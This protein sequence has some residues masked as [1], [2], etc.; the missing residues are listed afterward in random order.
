MVF[1]SK[2]K[3]A[4]WNPAGPPG[5][6]QRAGPGLRKTKKGFHCLRGLGHTGIHAKGAAQL[7]LVLQTW[8]RMELPLVIHV[9]GCSAQHSRAP[10]LGWGSL[11]SK[12]PN[13]KPAWMRCAGAIPLTSAHCQM[14]PAAATPRKAARPPLLPPFSSMEIS[15][16]IS[17]FPGLALAGL[18]LVAEARPASDFTALVYSLAHFLSFPACALAQVLLFTLCDKRLHYCSRMKSNRM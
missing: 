18:S 12:E 11:T 8:C 17:F 14:Q 5:S 1:Q 3:N 16:G 15:F 4:K 7:S 2:V 9:C 6:T 10:T 13:Q